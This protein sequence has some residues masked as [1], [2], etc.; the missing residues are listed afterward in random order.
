[1][2][3]TL[4]VARP[5]ARRRRYDPGACR[6]HSPG[7]A[8]WRTDTPTPST[9]WAGPTGRGG[10]PGDAGNGLQGVSH[11]DDDLLF[12]SPP[13]LQFIERGDSITTLFLTAGDD[14]LAAAYWQSREEGAKAAYASMS[15]GTVTW[16]DTTAAPGTGA[17]G[18]A[19]AT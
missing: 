9:G 15:G 18:L 11:E 4:G 19:R 2:P 13:L 1:M 17:A 12:M 16:T 7:G 3:V 5:P 8:T 14:G 6:S 10:A